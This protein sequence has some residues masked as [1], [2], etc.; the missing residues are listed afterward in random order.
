MT[1]LALAGVL[2]LLAGCG[3][4]APPPADPADAQKANELREVYDLIAL[5]TEGA[6]RPPASFKELAK[7]ENAF[8]AGYE[9]VRSGKVVVVWGAGPDAGSGRVLAYEKA[10]KTDGGWVVRRN[11]TPERLPA[12]GVVSA[13]GP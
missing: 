7:L 10:A 11:G 9:L 6:G 4:L 8:P 2:G 5:A 3:P 13:L 12:A 1:R